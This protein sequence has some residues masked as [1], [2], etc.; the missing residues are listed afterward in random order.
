MRLF[1]ELFARTRICIQNFSLSLCLSACVLI[2]GTFSL[3]L[4]VKQGKTALLLK[5]EGNASFK[6]GKRPQ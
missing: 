1:P 6:L 2:S 3:S 5:E 4:Q